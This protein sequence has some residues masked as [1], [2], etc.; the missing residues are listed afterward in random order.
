MPLGVSRT[1]PNGM[2]VPDLFY[3]V[4]LELLHDGV[5]SSVVLVIVELNRCCSSRSCLEEHKHLFRTMSTLR[6]RKDTFNRLLFLLCAALGL[7]QL[8][9]QWLQQNFDHVC[10]CCQFFKN[11]PATVHDI[12]L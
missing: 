12:Y 5:Q 3:R 11:L 2:A 10:D 1:K 6:A 7:L 9:I 4:D 8:S